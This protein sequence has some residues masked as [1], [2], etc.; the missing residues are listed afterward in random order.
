MLSPVDTMYNSAGLSRNVLMVWSLLTSSVPLY[1]ILTLFH[2]T[3]AVLFVSQTGQANSISEPFC[4]LAGGSSWTS[5]P[6]SPSRLSGQLLKK[7]LFRFEFKSPLRKL[8]CL[9][10]VSPRCL[11]HVSSISSSSRVTRTWNNL[12]YF[13]IVS[14]FPHLFFQCLNKWNACFNEPS[15]LNSQHLEYC[16]PHIRCSFFGE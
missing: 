10:K 11:L 9:P 8:F 12:S 14:H 16:L 7:R 5:F 3:C 13:F 6:T 1:N 4:A 15:A 2:F